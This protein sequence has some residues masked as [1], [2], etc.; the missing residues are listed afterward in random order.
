MGGNFPVG[1]LKIKKKILMHSSTEKMGIS[2]PNKESVG[3][4]LKNNVNQVTDSI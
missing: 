1:S 3:K 2:S 4:V